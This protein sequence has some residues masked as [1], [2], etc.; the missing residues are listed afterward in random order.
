MNKKEK[1]LQKSAV[2][3]ESNFI[4]YFCSQS[5]FYGILLLNLKCFVF[6]FNFTSHRINPCFLSIKS[7]FFIIC[8]Y[9]S[10][11]VLSLLLVINFN[12]V[13]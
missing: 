7:V 1:E 8:T 5:S 10:I 9:L 13:F 4:P 6:L 2:L 3:F 12:A 11:G